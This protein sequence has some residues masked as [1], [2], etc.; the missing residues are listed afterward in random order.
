MIPAPQSTVGFSYLDALNPAQR[1]AV[2]ALDGPLLVLA[3]AGTGKT[4]VLTS[5]L[6]HILNTRRAY[7]SQIL[8][9]TFT[10]KAALEM[11]RRVSAMMGAAVEGWWLGT[12][13]SLAAKLL[14]RHAEL[15]GLKPNFSI[16]DDD[17]QIRLLKQL[18]EAENLDSKKWP[19]RMLMG[20]IQKWK[21][22][23]ETPDDIKPGDARD[24][25]DGILPKLYRQYQER[26][27]TLNACDFGDLLMH[28]V[29][30]F[31]DPKNAD[32]LGKYQ[33]QFKYILVDEYQ[34]T[35][36]AQYMWLRLLAQKHK[37]ICCVGDDDQS[38]YGWRG[39]EIGNILKFEQDFPGAQVVRLEQN[40]RSTQHI[41]SAANGVISHNKN[42][43]GKNLWSGSGEGEKV[44]VNGVWDGPQ[45]A[46]AVAE[47]IESL[48][49]KKTNLNEIAILVRAAH[50][51]REFEERFIK[52]SIPYKVVGGLRFYERQEIRDAIAYLRV[53]VQPDDDLAFARIINVPKRG[54]GDAT[55][56]TLSAYARARSLPLVAALRL[57]LETEEFKPKVRQ[58]LHALMRDFDRWRDQLRNSSH[59]DLVQVM[60]DESGYTTMWQNDKSPE[61]AGRLENLK[62]FVSALEEFENLDTFL[63][64]VALVMENQE[65]EG[66]E[67]VSVMTLHAAKGLEFDAVFL[68]GWEEGLF[69]SQR[70]MDE[71][72]L[73]GLEEERR[74]AYVGITRAKKCAYIFFAAN[75]M[76]YGNWQSCLPSRFIDELPKDHVEVI[77][78]QG[79]STQSRGGYGGGYGGNSHG[80]GY[81]GGDYGNWK[82]KRAELVDNS[83]DRVSATIE[84]EG[85]FSNGDRVFHQKFGP[86]TVVATEGDKLDI[87]FDKAGR[88]KVMDS[89]VTKEK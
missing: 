41:L 83:M 72:G 58:T 39:A 23:A 28:M 51:T 35:N 70:S 46:Q 30:I 64:H 32:V 45:E 78:E 71:T 34:D 65:K 63:E 47:E 42:R 77:V 59:T 68:P 22:R 2:E 44:R 62:E 54:I 75:R 26:L 17:D 66:A 3:G 80:G 48:Q 27:R 9:V 57:L 82:P 49:R 16:L 7:P 52:E 20:V 55:L 69:P 40:Y 81:G 12:F 25:A 89:F 74:L 36:V 13:H 60:L 50:Q 79:L 6:S 85:G 18:L 37:N 33:E 15:V 53:I 88:K 43:L 87:K 11:K 56:N 67:M 21:D 31:R 14:R 19:A 86:G 61:A 38:I 10:N 76:I 1:A 73:V 84:S 29:T 4:K 24:I 8:S 5:R